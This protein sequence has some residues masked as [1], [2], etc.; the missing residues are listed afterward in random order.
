MKKI[1]EDANVALEIFVNAN[2]IKFFTNFL[3]Y[4]Y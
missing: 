3:I 2:E 4:F 1:Q